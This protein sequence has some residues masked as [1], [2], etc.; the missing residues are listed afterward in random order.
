MSEL[1]KELKKKGLL[2]HYLKG[3]ELNKK[4]RMQMFYIKK[5]IIDNERKNSI[6]K[7]LADNRQQS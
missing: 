4:Q 2:T 3:W 6:R 7:N 1:E 5:K